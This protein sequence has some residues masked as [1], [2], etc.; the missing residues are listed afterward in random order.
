MYLLLL[1]LKAVQILASHNLGNSCLVFTGISVFLEHDVLPKYIKIESQHH[2]FF[3][4]SFLSHPL[5]SSLYIVHLQ[6]EERCSCYC[7]R[8]L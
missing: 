6:Q 3:S 8:I 2:Q 7:T 5:S 4:L 1:G